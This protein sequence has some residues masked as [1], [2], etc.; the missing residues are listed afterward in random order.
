MT[1]PWD[2]PYATRFAGRKPRIAIGFVG[3]ADVYAEVFS[4]YVV[5]AMYVGKKYHNDF[6][7]EWIHVG[8]KEQYRARNYIVER[9]QVNNCDFLLMMDDDHTISDCPDILMHFFREE[10]PLQGGLYVCRDENQMTPVLLKYDEQAE[11]CRWMTMAEVPHDGGPVD[12][13]GGGVN[14]IDMTV[15]DFLAQPHWWPYPYDR[16][17]VTFLP[18]QRYGLDLQLS[19]GCKKL[20]IQPWLN[21]HVKVGHVLNERTILRPPTLEVGR[22]P[23]CSGIVTPVEGGYR[24]MACAVDCEKAAA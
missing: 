7:I 13:L 5:W 12:V 24:C 3:Y 9:A 17:E 8:K 6:E 22:C 10:K 19:L 1:R 15:F 11:L 4:S 2:E 20:G 18:N 16:R 21:K 23:Q 14:W